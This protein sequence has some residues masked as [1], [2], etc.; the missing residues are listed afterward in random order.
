MHSHFLRTGTS[1]DDGARKSN[2]WLDQLHSANGAPGVE[3]GP[4]RALSRRQ[5]MFL[6]CC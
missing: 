6:F 3:F 4:Y 2:N 1:I 5:M